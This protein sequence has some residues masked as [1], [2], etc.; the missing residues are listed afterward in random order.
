MAKTVKE[1]SFAIGSQVLVRFESLEI[2]CI[3]ADAKNSY[4][5]E[6]FLVRP[7]TGN[8]EQWIEMSRL[9]ARPTE[10]AR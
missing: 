8:G 1:L 9:I 10:V 4:G 2:Q 3:V 6:R 7:V 5:R